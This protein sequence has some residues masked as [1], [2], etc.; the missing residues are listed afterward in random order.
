MCNCQGGK[1]KL[2]GKAEA[3]IHDVRGGDNSWQ[4]MMGGTENK[5][6]MS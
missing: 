5:N 6:S 2:R 1:W 3:V 4:V